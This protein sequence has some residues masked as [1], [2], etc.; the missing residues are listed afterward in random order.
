MNRRHILLIS[1]E[2]NLTVAQVEATASLL[3]EGAT[4]PFISRYRKEATGSLDETVVSAIRDRLSQL[5]VLDKRREAI[6]KSLEDQG[7]LTDELKEKV[8][9]AETLSV[10]EDLYLPYK[11]KRR[12]RATIAREKGLEP[13]AELIFEQAPGTNPLLEAEKFLDPEKSV[14]TVEEALSGARDI[15]AERMNEDAEARSKLREMFLKKGIMRSKVIAGKEADGILYKDYHDW[16]EPVSGAPSHRVLAARRAEKE[17]FLTVHVAPLEADAL[18]ALENMFLKGAGDASQQVRLALHDGYKRLLGPSLETETK[19]W[20]KERA[21]MEAIRIFA[22]NVRQLL[23][24][25]PLGP[26][27]IMA[28]D[29]GFRTGC[30][31]VCLDPPGSPVSTWKRTRESSFT[32]RPSTRTPALNRPPRPRSAS[33]PSSRNC[34]SRASPSETAP[35]EGKRKR[36]S[37]A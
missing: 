19:Q 8:L 1:E 6:I 5:E 20:A 9:Q 29:P 36:S 17:G 13:L 37:E 24:A 4:I 25:S 11:P 16:E 30:K 3:E 7:K 34:T 35:L 27:T 23:M 18:G 10:L 14:F 15:I 33:S 2:L 28:L 22:D 26:R 32:M 21:D 12:T 31:L